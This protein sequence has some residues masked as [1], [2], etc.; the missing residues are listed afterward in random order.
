[1]C[2]AHGRDRVWSQGLCGRDGGERPEVLGSLSVLLRDEEAEKRLCEG[3]HT[4]TG[5]REPGSGR[6]LPTLDLGLPAPRTDSCPVGAL[7]QGPLFRQPRNSDPRKAGPLK[8]RPYSRQPRPGPEP[9]APR[10]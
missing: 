6:A 10:A 9:G 5:R 3:R 1:M 7:V 4:A 2:R 8:G